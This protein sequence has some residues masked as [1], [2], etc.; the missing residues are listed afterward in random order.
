MRI[1]LL[2]AIVASMLGQPGAQRFAGTWT[3]E[4]AGKPVVRLELHLAEGKLAGSIQLADI[5]IGSTGEVENVLSGLS[6]ASPLFDIKMDGQT[7]SFARHDGNEVD[8]FEM[9]LKGDRTIE[10]RFVPTEEMRRELASQ[11]V[12]LPKPIPLRKSVQ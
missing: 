4:Q 8:P 9:A 12:P 10:L 2:A 7:V 6:P 11:G 1:S 5:H 3:A